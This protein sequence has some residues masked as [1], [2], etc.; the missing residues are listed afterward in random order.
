MIRSWRDV[1]V[2]WDKTSL[3]NRMRWLENAEVD[4]LNF[5]LYATCNWKKLPEKIKDALNF[6]RSGK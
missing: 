4:A 6:I 3:Q 1:A 2:L 5:T